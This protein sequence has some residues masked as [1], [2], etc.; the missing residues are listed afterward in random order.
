VGP[1]LGVSDG[2]QVSFPK[3]SVFMGDTA[4]E[5]GGVVAGGQGFCQ[6]GELFRICQEFDP[7]HLYHPFNIA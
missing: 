5:V 3:L 2:P 7:D 4:H 1:G 6:G